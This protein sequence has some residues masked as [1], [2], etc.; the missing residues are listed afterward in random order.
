MARVM[1]NYLAAHFPKLN[2]NSVGELE[3]IPEERSLKGTFSWTIGFQGG[4]K[5]D[6]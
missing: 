4:K 1:T 6:N 2:K 3:M 5:V